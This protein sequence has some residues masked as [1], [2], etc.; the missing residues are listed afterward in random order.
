MTTELGRLL[1][2]RWPDVAPS[3][4]AY[5]ARGTLPLVQ[6]PP[7]GVWGRSGATTWTTAWAWFGPERTAAAPDL[8]DPEVL[9]AEQERFVRRY[10]AA[11]GPASVADLQSWSGLTGMRSV[12]DR[13]DLVRYRADPS[14][15]GVREREVLDLPGATLPDPDVPAPVRFLPDYDNVLLGHADRT[16][17]I[18]ARSTARTWPA[19]TGSSRPRSCWTGAWRAPGT[20]PATR[21]AADRSRSRCDR[22]RARPPRQ[23]DELAGGGGGAGRA[24]GREADERRVVGGRPGLTQPAVAST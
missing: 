24:H 12:V 7:R 22:S 3:T 6:V 15:G 5:A 4:L 13:L 20:C 16:R 2:Q 11:F 8:A 14:P 9:A 21:R 17:I 19:R 1:A 23:R 18:S 10:L